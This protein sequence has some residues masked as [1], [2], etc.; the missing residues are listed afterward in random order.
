MGNGAICVCRSDPTLAKFVVCLG[1][2]PVIDQPTFAA[3][4][5]AAW[6]MLSRE[7]GAVDDVSIY[8]IQT[9]IHFDLPIGPR[10]ADDFPQE[11]L[12]FLPSMEMQE[13]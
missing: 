8:E 10:S 1:G 9:G 5:E 6:A 7:G 11:A 13:D 3:A 12:A 2:Y 4:T